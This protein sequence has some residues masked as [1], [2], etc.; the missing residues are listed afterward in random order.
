MVAS[1]LTHFVQW[2]GPFKK[3][4]GNLAQN[5]FNFEVFRSLPLLW[6]KWK[7]EIQVIPSV[8]YT[9]N[10]GSK[11]TFYAAHPFFS[12]PRSTFWTEKVEGCHLLQAATVT[13]CKSQASC[14][15]L[16]LGLLGVVPE[17]F[18]LVTSATPSY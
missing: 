13:L 18:K 11:K 5:S 12:T 1:V 16:R 3:P 10:V 15:R 6:T 4:I 9:R 8:P 17:Y 2:A 14:L 7:T